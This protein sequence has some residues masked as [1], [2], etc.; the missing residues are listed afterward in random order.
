MINDRDS[1]EVTRKRA[2]SEFSRTVPLGLETPNHLFYD[3]VAN[4]SGK[5]VGTLWLAKYTEGENPILFLYNIRI[6][7]EFQNKGYGTAVLKAYE[8]KGKEMG[9]KKLRL[10]VFAHNEGARKLYTREGF[11]LTGYNMAKNLK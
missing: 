7:D 5:K 10:H 1:E 2:I 4:D 11:F 3:V 9:A 8:E 6:F